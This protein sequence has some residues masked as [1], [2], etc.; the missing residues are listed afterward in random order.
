MLIIRTPYEVSPESAAPAELGEGFGP[1]ASLWVQR[2]QGLAA[3][4]ASGRGGGAH[5]P[6]FQLGWSQVWNLTWR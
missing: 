2:G 4:A 5:R 6:F 1:K 3:S